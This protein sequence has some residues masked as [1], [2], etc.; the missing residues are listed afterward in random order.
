M[1]TAD[2]LDL[3]DWI[4]REQRRALPPRGSHQAKAEWLA[5]RL[6]AGV[7][8]RA[9]VAEILQIDPSDVERIVAGR[10]TISLG[11]WSRLAELARALPVLRNGAT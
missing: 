9:A 1:A 7:L 8:T 4:E 6:G 10:C 5:A 3:L 2:Q 11:A